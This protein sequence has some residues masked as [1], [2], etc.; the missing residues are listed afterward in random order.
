MSKG[1]ETDLN[2]VFSDDGENCEGTKVHG[3]VIGAN[4]FRDSCASASGEYGVNVDGDHAVNGVNGGSGSED[5][6]CSRGDMS[7]VNCRKERSSPH[8]PSKRKISRFIS[9]KAL[10]STD[11]NKSMNDI[12]TSDK[13]SGKDMKSHTA[14]VDLSVLL[15]VPALD[16]DL[17]RDE[18][19]DDESEYTV[20]EEDL[21]HL[22]TKLSEAEIEEVY[23]YG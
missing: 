4:G 17:C 19:D 15:R 9:K 23:N 5:S 6:S 16:M 14:V 13:S 18:D 10:H 8:S 22:Q 20:D 12:D 1:R 3:V 21:I 7:S 2:I 11:V